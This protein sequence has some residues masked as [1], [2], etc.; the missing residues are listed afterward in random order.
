MVGASTSIA[1][2][3]PNFNIS[4]N[5]KLAALA[6]GETLLSLLV[7]PRAIKAPGNTTVAAP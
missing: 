5:M 2:E 4:Q 3:T 1:T 6:K 7:M